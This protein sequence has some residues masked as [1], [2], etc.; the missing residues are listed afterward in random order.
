[1]QNFSI[2]RALYLTLPGHQ[3][4]VLLVQVFDSE[5][6]KMTLYTV[7]GYTLPAF[8]IIFAL[9]IDAVWY[10][11]TTYGGSESCWLSANAAFYV[12]FLIPLALILLI[13][14]SMLG[15]V[16]IKVYRIKPRPHMFGHARGWFSLAMLLG[17][18]WALGLLAKIYPSFAIAVIFVLLNSLQVSLRLRIRKVRTDSFETD[19]F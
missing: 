13:N 10:G 17:A 2:N 5:Q 11:G 12:T 6:K 3:I 4:Y 9:I 7:I 1:M 18:T 16:I 15:L 8:F 14:L 19:Y